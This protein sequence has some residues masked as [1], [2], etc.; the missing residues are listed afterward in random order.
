[1]KSYRV[2]YENGVTAPMR[3]INPGEVVI[4][5]TPAKG[6]MVYL[7]SSDL[8]AL[9]LFAD[10]EIAAGRYL[11]GARLRE[12]LSKYSEAERAGALAEKVEG[13]SIAMRE[14]HPQLAAIR[15]DISA[16]DTEVVLTID[17]LAEL[18]SRFETAKGPRDSALIEATRHFH[19][20]LTELHEKLSALDMRFEEPLAELVVDTSEKK[21]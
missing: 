18:L 2:I 7:D 21:P 20:S 8:A 1:M 11:N 9:A 14:A 16:V 3:P 17:A 12:L 19:G 15:T 4:S 6:S 5:P 10:N 13:L